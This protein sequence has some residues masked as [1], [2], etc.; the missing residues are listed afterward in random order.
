[1]RARAVAVGRTPPRRARLVCRGAGRV[2]CRQLALASS[3]WVLLALTALP[4]GSAL[5]HAAAFGFILACPGAAIVR[6]WPG[7]DRLERVVV[8]VAISV[9]LAILTAEGLLLVRAWSATVALVI[10]AGVTSVCALAPVTAA[11]GRRDVP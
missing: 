6:Q 5:R 4:S 11:G 2:R 7:R 9:A 1:V 10:L 8:A 3:G